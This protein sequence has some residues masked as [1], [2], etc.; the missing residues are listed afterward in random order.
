VCQPND[1]TF[2]NPQVFDDVAVE[3]AM[4]LLQFMSEKPPE[5]LIWRGLK[6]LLRCCQ[7]ARSEVPNF[8][9]RIIIVLRK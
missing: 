3:L 7:L 4:A 5:P 9:T 8:I 2:L 6:S 1:R